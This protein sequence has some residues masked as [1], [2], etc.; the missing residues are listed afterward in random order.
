MMRRPTRLDANWFLRSWRAPAALTLLLAVA[1]AWW[2]APRRTTFVISADGGAAWTEDQAPPQ[3]SIVWPTAEL[4]D[5]QAI[6]EPPSGGA[7][8]LLGQTAELPTE[9]ETP[10]GARRA[11]L[12]ADGV[13]YFASNQPGGEGG[14]DLYL[15]RRDGDR[16]LPSEN[17]GP[18]VNG[19]ADDLDPALSPDGLRLFFASSRKAN[20]SSAE[21]DDAATDASLDLYSSLR[22]SPD[23]DWPQA[24][25]LDQLNLAASDET[26]P[27]VA[28]GH[29]YFASDRPHEGTAPAHFDLYRALQFADG[30]GPLEP[31]G[32]GINTPDDEALPSLSPDGFRL[33]FVR[34]GA[35]D[36][37]DAAATVYRSTARE[38]V[39]RPG[40][41]TSRW[42]ALAGVWWQALGLTLLVATLAAAA[43]F[44]RGWLFERASAARFFLGSLLLHLALLALLLF[45]P[46]AHTLVEQ[47][48]RIR[49]EGAEM[50]ADNLHQSHR[51]GEAAY[52]KVADLQS[53]AE[54]KTSEVARQIAVPTNVPVPADRP[55]PTL[56]AEMARALPPTH[57]LIVP[58]RRAAVEPAAEPPPERGIPHD[59]AEMIAA[60]LP[61]EVV[62]LAATE[63]P[64]EAPLDAP[65]DAGLA[66]EAAATMP[67]G[68]SLPPR[69]LP[70]AEVSAADLTAQP[71]DVP[72]DLPASVPELPAVRAAAE[73]L[74]APEMA[75]RPPPSAVE[76]APLETPLSGQ[77]VGPRRMTSEIASP[78]RIATAPP[79]LGEQAPAATTELLPAGPQPDLATTDDDQAPARAAPMMVAAAAERAAEAPAPLPR[80]IAEMPEASPAVGE[81]ALARQA[82]DVGLPTRAM[83][84][85]LP[86]LSPPDEA[87]LARSLR[88]NEPAERPAQPAPADVARAVPLADS[89]AE[90]LAIEP[91]P[92]PGSAAEM[93][94]E[95][96]LSG[97]DAPLP[98]SDSLPLRL[99]AATPLEAGGPRAALR[100]DVAIGTLAE[101]A[102][103]APP[104]L[105]P[106]ASQLSRPPADALPVAYAEDNVGMRA[107]F[108]LR[109]GDVRRE[110][111]ELFGGSPETEAAV[112]RGLVWL[113]AHQHEDGHWSLNNFAAECRDHPQCGGHG[114]VYSDT[115]AT[116]LALL[117][118]LGTG[119]TQRDGNYQPTVERGIRWLVEHQKPDGNLFSEPPSNAWMYSHGIAAIALCEA[120]GLTEDAALREPAQR[121]LDFIVAAQN[122]STGGWRYTPGEPGDTS[123]VGWQVMALKS[124]EMAGL[125]VPPRALELA[126][127][128]LTFAEGTGGA[129]GQFG[130]TGPGG[131]LAMSAEGLL[132]RQFLG[133]RRDN[134]SMRG[135]AAYL[136]AHLPQP[137]QETS[138]YWYYGTQVMYHMQGEYWD[139]WN[140]A[141]RDSLV[142]SQI[143]E[144]TL[145]GTWEPT[146]SW[147]GSG[148]RIYATS[149]RLL[150]LEIYYRHLPLYRQLEE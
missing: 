39:V 49:L 32:R 95:A 30:Y 71:A 89:P 78:L 42:Q 29:L 44:A 106:I 37:P 6:E 60:E 3:R 147:E 77:I 65:V 20:A 116:G 92:V 21:D 117:P 120:Y 86:E 122:P 24:A 90:S 109:Q 59:P 35:E 139:A 19:P 22:S 150:M 96:A 118:F 110:F 113:A 4:Q 101:R 23:A 134:P 136:V 100:Q 129:S 36:D 138:Y 132:C 14:Y 64:A 34:E 104:T 52:E 48:E 119:Q 5:P 121:S 13:L 81:L 141:L 93:P 15:S 126:A 85:E 66:R 144:G 9:L 51:P 75:A 105:S 72:P 61:T 128:W 91:P 54:V 74:P 43:L 38:V 41:D 58:P 47:V 131:S 83:P 80:S 67:A 17:L 70:P 56:P 102:V 69:A 26:A 18:E 45:V 98:R 79:R 76:T 25:P 73:A 125:A 99:D 115:A 149:L 135:G 88:N 97:V 127:T 148:G 55:A 146:D 112:D 33:A 103:D 7:R 111:I 94:V 124:G 68:A 143:K 8:R 87:A 2:L 142:A 12:A 107:M 62:Q 40:W 63:L 50:A 137:G 11:F 27:F 133:A 10:Q 123:V 57:I 140:L 46:L 28:A 84:T 1:A 130:Y 114:G 31:L 16:W 82:A 108:T 53:V 145:S